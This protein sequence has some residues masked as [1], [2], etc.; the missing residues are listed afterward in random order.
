MNINVNTVVTDTVAGAEYLILWVSPDKIYGYWHNLS[1]KSRTPVK[2]VTANITDGR[3]ETDVFEIQPRPEETLSVKERE[4]RN[5]RWDLI[6]IPLCA[7]Y[8][9]LILRHV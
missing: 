8:L 2:F 1:G 4:Y 6:M 3:H 5:K 9:T 7:L